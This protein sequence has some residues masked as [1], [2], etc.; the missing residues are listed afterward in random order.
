MHGPADFIGASSGSFDE[1]RHANPSKRQEN[2]PASYD[3]ITELLGAIN[4]VEMWCIACASD[5]IAAVA[6][7]WTRRHGQN[8][9]PIDA[10]RCTPH[11]RASAPI[12]LITCP[13]RSASQTCFSTAEVRV[14]PRVWIIG[15][16]LLQ[17]PTAT[18]AFPNNNRSRN[19]SGYFWYEV[20]LTI[21]CGE[22]FPS[23][24]KWLIDIERYC[25]VP[26]IGV[27][28]YW[29][30]SYVWGGSQSTSLTKGN[31]EE[32][33]VEDALVSP[34]VQLP[35]TIKD[36]MRLVGQLNGRYLWV[37]K[38]CIPQDDGPAK[39]L[40]LEAMAAIYARAYATIVAAQGGDTDEGLHGVSGG[41]KTRDL[42]KFRLNS[43]PANAYH[44]RN[45]DIS[46]FEEQTGPIPDVEELENQSEAQHNLGALVLKPCDRTANTKEAGIKSAPWPDFYRFARL[47]CL[48]NI[49]DFTFPE[50]ALD[51]FDGATSVFGPS[52]TGGLVSGLPQMFF[53]AAL[54]W[55]PNWKL[56]RRACA[57]PDVD[58]A[59]LPSWSWVG[60]QGNLHSE[61]WRSGYG[62]LRR[63]PDEYSRGFPDIWQ[64]CSW[65]TVST[66]KWWH[67]ATVDGHRTS[68]V[69]TSE[70][71]ES[72]DDASI[73]EQLPPGWSQKWCEVL[74]RL[75]FTH[76][77]DPDQDFWRP[78]PINSKDEGH[79][80]DDYDSRSRFLRC[81]T[82]RGYLRSGCAIRQ[83]H[84]Q[85]R[86]INLCDEDDTWAGATRLNL[87]DTYDPSWTF[88]KQFGVIPE[89]GKVGSSEPLLELIELSRGKVRDQVTERV[90]F[91]EWDE[92]ECPRHSGLYKF[93]NVMWVRW[94][95]GIAYRRAVGR[96]V[97]HIWE[98]IATEKI[99]VTI[100]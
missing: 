55:Q 30:L 81:T 54:L 19:T 67:S 11:F 79:R 65:R 36:A 37:D 26:G 75:Y 91:D 22:A 53:N 74:E 59:I 25:L 61:S 57:G 7:S 20:R 84:V 94:E 90:S 89:D 63:N 51:A 12:E 3:I 33:Q 46:L 21:K 73:I 58:H 40:E 52:F 27:D 41:S 82:R 14:S 99:H 72:P 83:G 16:T 70:T 29:T 13:T 92:P 66:V 64:P 6:E 32:L 77:S 24:P 42:R 80:P 86:A 28:R 17:Q 5:A 71:K 96:V 97:D 35:A 38:L 9:N 31:L 88:R 76:E 43:Q 68:I 100:G 95:N 98:K 15:M 87:A 18:I 10:D 23:S 85:C 45:D 60:W 50:D 93:Y 2:K 1:L 48:Y 47:V 62:Y 78:V 34:S 4:C 56:E 44:R 49:R 69:S 8:Q 39:K